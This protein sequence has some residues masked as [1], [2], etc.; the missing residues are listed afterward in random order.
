MPAPSSDHEAPALFVTVGT[1]L[2]PFDRLLRM[3]D[4]LAEAG[5][6]PREILAQ[7]GTCRYVPRSY[8][9]VPFLSQEEIESLCARAQVVIC[10]GGA[11]SIGTC[12]LL[13]RRPVVVPRRAALREIV[14]DHQLELCRRMAQEGRIYLAEDADTLAAAIDQARQARSATEPPPPPGGDRLRRAIADLLQR[15]AAD[16]ID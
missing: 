1:S 16:P 12:L 9:T 13:R 7:S 15:I 2:D 6:V 5:R 11:G 10:H 14:N 8:P 4:E 3:L